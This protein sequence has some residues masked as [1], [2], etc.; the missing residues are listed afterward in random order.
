M[1]NLSKHW[2]AIFV[3]GIIGIL[4]AIL[5]V[6]ATGFTLSVL[7]LLLGLYFFLDGLFSVIASF[8]AASN[9]KRWWLLFLEGLF[10]IVAGIFVFAKPDLT[11]IILVYIIAIWAIITGIF[12]FVASFISTWASKGK[13]FL[14]IAGVISV[15][16]GLIILLYPGISLIAM[17]WLA[18]IYAFVIGLTLII[19]SVK[20]RVQKQ[21]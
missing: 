13:V 7:I 11:L 14:G 17:I 20:L 9:H 6:T 4:F 5:L 18:A 10:S 15:I 1:E 8:M 19:F 16:L 3:R 21:D 2:W 12:E